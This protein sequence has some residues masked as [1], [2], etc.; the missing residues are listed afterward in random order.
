VSPLPS[1]GYQ[2]NC[3]QMLNVGRLT[4]RQLTG[5]TEVER[6]MRETVRLIYI[7]KSGVPKNNKK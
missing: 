7:Y 2:Q 3:G 1:G 4:Q 6:K 5:V